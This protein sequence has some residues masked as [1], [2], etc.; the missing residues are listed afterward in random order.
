MTGGGGGAVP[1]DLGG[2][3]LGSLVPLR[4]LEQVWGSDGDLYRGPI[5]Y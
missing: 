3:A 4:R 1:Q 2:G 5:P